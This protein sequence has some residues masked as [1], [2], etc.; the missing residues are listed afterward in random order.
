M[1]N[2]V[3]LPGKRGVSGVIVVPDTPAPRGTEGRAATPSG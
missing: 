2:E 3:A 1:G